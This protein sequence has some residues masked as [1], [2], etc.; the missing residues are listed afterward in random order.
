MAN[1]KV[2]PKVLSNLLSRFIDHKL[3]MPDEVLIKFG[4]FIFQNSSHADIEKFP[5]LRETLEYL[6][7]IT[8]RNKFKDLDELVRYYTSKR[9]RVNELFTK[10]EES[11]PE[12]CLAINFRRACTT[13][14]RAVSLDQI[15]KGESFYYPMTRE[16]NFE[17]EFENIS[18][19]NTLEEEIEYLAKIEGNVLL[20]QKNIKCIASD[21]I[22]QIISN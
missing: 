6:K 13:Y 4:D 22:N 7:R 10:L 2:N 18:Y 19:R 20:K 17:I 15:R 14:M 8:E 11:D 9:E 3:E 12:E 21:K 5:D 1:S 16:N